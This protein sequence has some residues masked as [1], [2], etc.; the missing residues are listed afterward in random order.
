MAKVTSNR[1]IPPEVIRRKRIL[2]LRAVGISII[3]MLVFI[4]IMR[5]IVLLSFVP[6]G[7]MNPTIK[8]GDIVL[9]NRLAYIKNEVERGDVIVFRDNESNAYLTKRVIALA[10]DT[11]ESK[12]GKV[13]V[14]GNELTETYLA[15]KTSTTDIPLQT[16][17]EDSYYVLGD[18]R[19]SSLDSRYLEDGYI[20][21]DSIKGKA[22]IDL[23]LKNDIGL[24][25]VR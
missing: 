15:E 7:S 4:A 6:S 5:F 23:R 20:H 8:E 24:H 16:I 1:V 22:W 25:I 9:Y 21:K 11:I 3:P 14:N 19:E 18:N 12:D 10:G 13:Y 2:K 17:P